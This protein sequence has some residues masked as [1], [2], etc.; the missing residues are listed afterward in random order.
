MSNVDRRKSLFYAESEAGMYD[1]TIELVVPNYGILHQCL[2]DLARCLLSAAESRRRGVV[3]DVGSGTGA[4]ALG[5]LEELPEIQIVAVDLCWPMHEILLGKLAA[6]GVLDRCRP[7]HGDFLSEGC[8]PAEIRRVAGEAFGDTCAIKM[9]VSAFALHHLELEEKKRAYS[10]AY[11]TLDPGG[12]FLL[13]DLFS[14][15]WSVI[16]QAAL[17]F[18]LQWIRRSFE[19]PLTAGVDVPAP[20]GDRKRLGELWQRHYERDNRLFPLGSGAAEV[21]EVQLLLGAGFDE[22]EVPYRFW[23]TGI[24]C[25]K[26]R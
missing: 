12:V 21:E 18:D 5:L 4:E 19:R 13:A 23:Q 7:I 1:D 11:E 17:D 20:A 2:K 22:V 15:G 9:V 6:Q 3:V 8:R 10:R 14:F 25:A 16:G 24:V 26:K